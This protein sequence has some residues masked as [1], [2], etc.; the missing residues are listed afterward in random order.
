MT[1][2]VLNYFNNL[3]E[4]HFEKKVKIIESEL[5]ELR[6]LVDKGSEDDLFGDTTSY[7]FKKPIEILIGTLPPTQEK[8]L[9]KAFDIK[10]TNVKRVQNSNEALVHSDKTTQKNIPE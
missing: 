2:I 10:E 7:N 9:L 4:K 3:S 5:S 8:R 6:K 1:S